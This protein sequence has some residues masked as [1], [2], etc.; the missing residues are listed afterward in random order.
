LIAGLDTIAGLDILAGLVGRRLQCAGVFLAS[1][2]MGLFGCAP[3]HPTP[4]QL[5]AFPTACHP[6]R[7]H[8][9]HPEMIIMPGQHLKIPSRPFIMLG[10]FLRNH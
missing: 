9:P 5:T 8:P 6:T 3:S 10:H 2:S 1:I 7:P 4:A